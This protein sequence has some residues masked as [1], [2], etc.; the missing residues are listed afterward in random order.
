MIFD[1]C[2]RALGTQRMIVRAI[3]N[4]LMMDLFIRGRIQ[5]L[6]LKNVFM[7]GESAVESLMILVSLLH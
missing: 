1:V 5:D 6:P 2:A 3:R 7:R 4:D